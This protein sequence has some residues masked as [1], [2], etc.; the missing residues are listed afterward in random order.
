MGMA[1]SFISAY[2]VH[3]AEYV[4]IGRMDTAKNPAAS[5]YNRGRIR[6]EELR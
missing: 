6:T 4:V 2:S 5:S 1:L 3:F